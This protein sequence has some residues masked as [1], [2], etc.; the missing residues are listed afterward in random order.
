MKEKIPKV[1]YQLPFVPDALNAKVCFISHHW[2]FLMS[3][4]AEDYSKSATIMVVKAPFTPET[5]AVIS[6]QNFG[7]F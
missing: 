1:C 3:I 5:Y 7:G 4:N 2:I 6:H